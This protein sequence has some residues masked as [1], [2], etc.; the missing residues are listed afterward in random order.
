MLPL[1]ASHLFINCSKNASRIRQ[2]SIFFKNKTLGLIDLILLPKV[3]SDEMTL[4]FRAI[5]NTSLFS[6][7]LSHLHYLANFRLT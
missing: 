5:S 2:Y 1:L 4:L 7:W 6:R 3:Y